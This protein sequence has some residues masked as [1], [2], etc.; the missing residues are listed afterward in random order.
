M[1]RD[2]LVINQLKTPFASQEAI[3]LSPGAGVVNPWDVYY[4]SEIMY[5]CTW[6]MFVAIYVHR[7]HVSLYYQHPPSS[8]PVFHTIGGPRWADIDGVRACARNAR[9]SLLMRHCVQS[10]RDADVG[11]AC[12]AHKVELHLNYIKITFDV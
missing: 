11:S 9:A 10:S 1:Y 5:H 4:S 3:S 6:V 2:D 12:S 8:L 7:E